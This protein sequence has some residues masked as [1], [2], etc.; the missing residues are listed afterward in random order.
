MKHPCFTATRNES[1]ELWWGLVSRSVCEGDGSLV[2][3]SAHT[4][5][6]L[7]RGL[8]ILSEEQSHFC[9]SKKEVQKVQLL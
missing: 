6:K 1:A 7:V 9:C 4:S 5:Q 3:A 8:D 2:R